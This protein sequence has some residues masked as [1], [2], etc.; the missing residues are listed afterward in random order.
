MVHERSMKGI[1]RYLMDE[2]LEGE[3]LHLHVTEVGPGER[4]HPPHR[5]GG[6]EAFYVLNGAGTLE[7][8]DERVALGAGEAAVFDPQRLHGLVNSG[9]APLRYVVVLRP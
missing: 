4:A 5:H 7:L 6:Y 1:A 3:P 2:R 8:D 9:D